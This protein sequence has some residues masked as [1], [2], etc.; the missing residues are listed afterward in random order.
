MQDQELKKFDF[1]PR[2]NEESK[3]LRRSL[4][5]LTHVQEKEQPPEEV[6]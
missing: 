1:K 6:K 2:I 3:E 5:D 4:S